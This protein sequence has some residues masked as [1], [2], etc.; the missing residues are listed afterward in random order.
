M[1]LMMSQKEGKRAQ[2]MELL[3]AGKIDQKEAGER[4]K[5]N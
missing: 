1:D 2:I 5:E 3:E 4:F